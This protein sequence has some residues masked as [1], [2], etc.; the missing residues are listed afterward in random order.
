MIR[1]TMRSAC[2][3][4]VSKVHVAPVLY[5]CRPAPYESYALGRIYTVF[6][7]TGV[8]LFRRER[9]NH[10]GSPSLLLTSYTHGI[11]RASVHDP[12]TRDRSRAA[13]APRTNIGVE[14]ALIT[15]IVAYLPRISLPLKRLRLDLC[16]SYVVARANRTTT[17]RRG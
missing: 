15:C 4:L 5:H 17:L 12:R 9:S 3:I 1:T 7:A 14:R 2:P 13:F 16:C 11:G 6:A 8:R 10:V